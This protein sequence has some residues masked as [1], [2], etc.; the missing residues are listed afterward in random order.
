MKL[1]GRYNAVLAALVLGAS[2]FLTL[3]P[4]VSQANPTPESEETQ[5]DIGANK[6][7]GSSQL[8][9]WGHEQASA[10]YG[11]VG[12]SE[13]RSSPLYDVRVAPTADLVQF[14]DSFV[15]MSVPRAGNGKVGYDDQDG[16]EFAAD[17]N[18]TMSWSSFEY[19][20]DVWVDV[21][22]NSGE[23]L[24][25]ADQVTVRPTNLGLE[26]KVVD[27]STI[28]ILIPFSSTGYRISVE[29]DSQLRTSYNDLSGDSGKLTTER[30]GNVRVHTEPQNSLMIFANPKLTEQEHSELVPSPADGKIF[31]PEEGKID[32]FE[33]LDAD[34]VYFKPGVYYMGSDYHA[35]LPERVTWVYLAPGA[36]VKGAFRFVEESPSLF[37]VT[38]RGVLSGEQYVYE[39]DTNND[40]KRSTADNCHSSC[41]KMLQF[42]SSDSPQQLILEGVTIKEPPYHSFVV[43]GHENGVEVPVTN[44]KMD[45]SNYKQVG[46]W[47]WQTD[48][49]ELYAGGE[50]RNTFFHAND[51]VL[52]MYHSDTKINDTV[53]WKN[54]NGPVIQF[55]WTPRDVRNVEVT[56]TNV[57]HNR[58]YWKDSKYNTCVVNSS[59][60]WEDMGA[61]DRADVTT[62]IQD[63][64]IVNTR[65][66]GELNCGVRWY[67]LSN[68]RNVE[69]DGFHIDQWNGLPENAQESLLKA[70]SDPLGNTVKFGDELSSGEGLLLKNYSV[71]GQFIHKAGNN[72]AAAELGRLNFDGELWQNWNAT[73]DS[74]ITQGRPELVVDGLDEEIY[75][76]S[77]VID[78]AG[79]TNAL[80]VIVNVNGNDYEVTPANGSF[81]VR[82]DLPDL[83]NNVVVT[84]TS[85]SGAQTVV[86]RTIKALGTQLGHAIDPSGDDY[87]P[88]EYVY[89]TDGA[90]SRGSFDLTAFSAFRDGDTIR[91]VS[92]VAGQINNPW[93][94]NGMSTQRLNIYLKDHD[95]DEVTGLLPGT[96]MSANGAWKY[97]VVADGRFSEARYSAGVY[98]SEHERVGE[99]ELAVDPAGTI[100]VSADA[101]L[102]SE[103]DLDA[104]EYQVSMLSNAESSEGVGGVR[105]V[106]SAECVNSGVCPDFVSAYRFSGG[107]GNFDDA[108]E[109]KDSDVSDANAI[110]I[111]DPVLGTAGAPSRTQAEQLDWRRGPVTV[112]YFQLIAPE[113]GGDADGGDADGGDADGGD[114]GGGDAGGGDAEGGSDGSHAGS[115]SGTSSE[116]DDR[117]SSPDGSA[118]GEDLA[119]TGVS[120]LILTASVAAVLLVSGVASLVRRRS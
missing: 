50:M 115:G 52:K 109:T 32:G 67:A 55:G 9:T 113:D 98:N 66:E 96:N 71:N 104:A 69:L 93:G 41:V 15:Y 62:T 16:A 60:H 114:A 87:G 86:R 120:G 112:D 17:A 61:T 77:R 105:P 89:P 40:Y 35:L 79:T 18:Y 42:E 82:V 11:R 58:M 91:F 5:S 25:S 26:K 85:T 4:A 46:S 68:V 57:I 102:F 72:W 95:S 117:P 88:G 43:Y 99:V 47:Y 103:L 45:V 83:R 51:D 106:Y 39:A 7:S 90:F 14:Q 2:S 27:S 49:I 28:R 13:V 12:D 64:R 38:G 36:Y 59:T 108:S 81:S 78:I 111:M 84:A 70:Y 19:D 101:H 75:A 54:E 65:V 3:Q 107:A 74:E 1:P 33:N 100:V 44:F 92:E 23:T 21:S 118:D 80:H 22:L 97:V 34:I 48:G 30:E 73:S 56:D 29:F 94:G 8:N 76:S 110:D 37:K 31:Y 119:E 20:R 10:T 53:I 63:V 24:Q 6:Q 116:G